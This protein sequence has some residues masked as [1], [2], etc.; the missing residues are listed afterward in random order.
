MSSMAT[1]ETSPSCWT[2]SFQQIG[3]G[4]LLGFC[5]WFVKN[6]NEGAKP[7][8]NTVVDDGCQHYEKKKSH[9]QT[10][11]FHTCRI[12]P[13]RHRWECTNTRCVW[14]LLLDCTSAIAAPETRR[15]T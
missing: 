14:S 13:E 9:P 12:C 4:N 10:P 1:R 6:R 15:P 5:T 2:C 3:G 8:P 7:I 11:H